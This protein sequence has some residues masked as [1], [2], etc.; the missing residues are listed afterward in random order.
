MRD[1][2]ARAPLD[3]V[4][5]ENEICVDSPYDRECRPFPPGM[6]NIVYELLITRVMADYISDISE[7]KVKSVVITGVVD[8][9][10]IGYNKVFDT[11]PAIAIYYVIDDQGRRGICSR[12]GISPIAK[13]DDDSI[14]IR[15]IF[16]AVVRACNSIVGNN[17]MQ[18]CVTIKPLIAVIG[19]SAR[20]AAVVAVVE[21]DVVVS[22]LIIATHTCDT[23]GSLIDHCVLQVAHVMR[24][25]TEEAVSSDVPSIQ[26]EAPEF[27]VT[28]AGRKCRPVDMKH[29][30]T[31]FACPN[32]IDCLSAI[33]FVGDPGIR[34]PTMGR[35]KVRARE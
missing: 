12:G 8:Y 2:T 14:S 28:R 9:P 1:S 10:D 35:A 18:S 30:L 26:S 13:I 21:G 15:V 11:A 3:Q 34:L 33:A 27:E 5:A 6:D 20:P 17:V 23:S 24:A 29:A 4:V 25:L 7:A 19:D 32:D 16:G 22:S 31:R